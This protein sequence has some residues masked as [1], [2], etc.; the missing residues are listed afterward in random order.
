M[1]C[2]AGACFSRAC[3]SVIAR[4]CSL[5]LSSRGGFQLVVAEALFRPSSSGLTRGSSCFL[6]FT[7]V[8]IFFALIF[9]GKLTL[10]LNIFSVRGREG[11]CWP[12]RP[13]APLPSPP[14]PPSLPRSHATAGNCGERKGIIPMK[15]A[16]KSSLRRPT[17]SHPREGG[18]PVAFWFLRCPVHWIPRSG[19][20]MTKK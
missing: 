10:P 20:G 5:A 2:L 9:W 1:V 18:D 13:K 8:F 15:I 12:K 6:I 7:F 3:P 14:T 16:D 17:T 19:R 11:V 4:A